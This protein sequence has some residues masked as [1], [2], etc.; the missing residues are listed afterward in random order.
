[1]V[2]I[3]KDPLGTKG[4]MLTTFIASGRRYCPHAGALGASGVT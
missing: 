1:M 2:Q 3:T 4:A